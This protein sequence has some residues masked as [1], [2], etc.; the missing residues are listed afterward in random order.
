MRLSQES[1]AVS[2]RRTVCDFATAALR[3]SSQ[4]VLHSR[5]IWT[6]RGYDGQD[7][8]DLMV[9]L[10]PFHDGARRLGLDVSQIFDDAGD[11]VGG[12]ATTASG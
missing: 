12:P 5:L 2:P 10:V 8:R 6:L 4:S 9:S 3:E 11:A 1:E 7:A